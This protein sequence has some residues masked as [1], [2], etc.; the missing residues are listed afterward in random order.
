MSIVRPPANNALAQ[1][2]SRKMIGNKKGK[3]RQGL[4]VNV[5]RAPHIARLH[6]SID[7]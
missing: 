6:K 7:V 1:T 4:R 5:Q 3:K 2:D